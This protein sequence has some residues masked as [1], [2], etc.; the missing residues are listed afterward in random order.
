MISNE[1][2]LPNEEIDA[3]YDYN[4]D[5]EY[6]FWEEDFV[7]PEIEHNIYP[8]TNQSKKTSTKSGCT[9]VWWLNMIERL[10]GIELSEEESNNLADEVVKYCVEEW[11]YVIWSWWSTYTA[12]QYV[13]KRR[14][15]IWYKRFDK[16]KVFYSRLL[17]NN[18]LLREAL[19]KWHFV[20]FTYNLYFWEDQINWLVYRDKYPSYVWH[21]TNFV[22]SKLITSVGWA[23]WEWTDRWVYDN[24]Y[25]SQW[26]K[27]FIKDISKYINKWMY[28]YMYLILP[29]SC[30]WMNIEEQKKKIEEEKAVNALI[31]SLTTVRWS[32]PEKYQNK[33]SALAKELRE[34]YPEARTLVEDEKLKHYQSVTDQLS[35]NWKWAEESEQEE[36]AKLA[37]DLRD[38]FWLK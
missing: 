21:R 35:F 9:I 1:K 31:W 14:N 29:E 23:S 25:W 20:W 4:Y 19:D 17:W 5:D 38:K 6:A 7:I 24:Y 26:Y 30:L 13:V 10:Y 22:S 28:S 8:K 37:K 18:E 3:A 32:M 11:W 36:Y 27:Y 33:L 34:D 15:T 12:I 2:K 16:E